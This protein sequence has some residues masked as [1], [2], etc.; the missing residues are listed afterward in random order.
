MTRHAMLYGQHAVWT[1]ERRSRRGCWSEALGHTKGKL[2][3]H[4]CRII[5]EPDEKCQY[6]VEDS[7]S[8]ASTPDIRREAE[9]A[10]CSTELNS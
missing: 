2:N 10:M 4:P 1:L 7:A 9:E 8:I 6:A 5:V 3:Q